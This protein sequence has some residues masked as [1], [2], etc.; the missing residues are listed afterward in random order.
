[1]QANAAF[2]GDFEDAVGAVARSMEHSEV[3]MK[4]IFYSGNKVLRIVAKGA[5]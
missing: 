3:P 1:M 5:Q 2:A 4:A